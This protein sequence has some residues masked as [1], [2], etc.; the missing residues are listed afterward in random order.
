M[1]RGRLEAGAEATIPIVIAWHF[2]N[3]DRVIGHVGDQPVN[4]IWHPFYTTRICVGSARSA[5]SGFR[6]GSQ[7]T[8]PDASPAGHWHRQYPHPVKP[9]LD[10]ANH[11]SVSARGLN[12]SSH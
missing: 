1:V 4:L 6:D 2:P 3:C 9:G 12:R 8:T 11:R 7:A 10:R 5:P